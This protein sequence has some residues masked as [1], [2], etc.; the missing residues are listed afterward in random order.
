[1]SFQPFHRYKYPYLRKLYLKYYPSHL[2]IFCFFFLSWLNISGTLPDFLS[3]VCLLVCLFI[4]YLCNINLSIFTYLFIYLLTTIFW[5]N[6][7]HRGILNKYLLNKYMHEW[8]HW[9]EWS[10]QNTRGTK[11][12]KETTENSGEGRL[13]GLVEGGV[14][15]K[16]FGENQTLLTS[17]FFLVQLWLSKFPK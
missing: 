11:T 10:Y 15:W 12:S 4:I 1:M 7:K 5:D 8:I 13:Q 6:A 9:Y 14:W 17:C 3:S 16:E 2:S